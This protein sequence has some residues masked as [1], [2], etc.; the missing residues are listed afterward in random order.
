MTERDFVCALFY[1]LLVIQLICVD[2]ADFYPFEDRT[3]NH[4]DI[5]QYSYIHSFALR[6]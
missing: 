4:I 2:C 5:L 1:P 3:S 6:V